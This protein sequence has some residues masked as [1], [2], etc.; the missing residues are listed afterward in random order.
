MVRGPT[1]VEEHPLAVGGGG[2]SSG[3]GDT[4]RGSGSGVALLHATAKLANSSAPAQPPLQQQN[5]SQKLLALDILE[6][7]NGASH[8]AKGA[9]AATAAASNGKPKLFVCVEKDGSGAGAAAGYEW[10]AMGVYDDEDLDDALLL[11][12]HCAKGPHMLWVGAEYDADHEEVCTED[13]TLLEWAC[14]QVESGENGEW[15]DIFPCDIRLHRSGEEDDG[16]WEA[17]NEGF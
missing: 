6:G 12:L 4:G 3:G 16:F 15:R 13:E 11:L 1:P 10:Q 17:F 9:A 2:S 8:N 7:G 14:Q 5:Q